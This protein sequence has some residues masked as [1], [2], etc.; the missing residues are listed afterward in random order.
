MMRACIVSDHE[1]TSTRVRQLLLQKGLDR[2]APQVLSL[3]Q[4]AQQLGGAQPDLLVVTLAPDADNALAVLGNLRLLT[5]ARILAVG[6]AADSRLILRAL[7]AGAADYV[8]QA[9]LEA[10]LVDALARVRAEMPAQAEPGRLLA[11]LAPSG[12]SGSSTLAV[13]VATVLAG[14]H[15]SSALFDLK[16]EAG[17]LAA[18]LDLRPTHTIAELCL[19]AASMDRVMFERSLSRHASGVHLL[20]A[21]R[22]RADVAQVTPDAVRQAL[23][24]ARNLFPY[25]VADLDHSFREEQLEVLSQADVV[26]VVL[27]LDFTALRNTQRT[28]EYLEQGGIPQDRVR[29]VVNRYGQP[30]EVPAAKAEEALGVKIAHYVPDEPKTVNRANNSGVP[31][32]LESPRASVSRSLTK[33]AASVNGRHTKH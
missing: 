13:N 32:V 8:D 7:R 5:A 25:V 1:P 24:V 4:A 11:L 33:L 15:K 3:V 2:P 28:L 21:P 18:L 26:L 16:L 6:P 31:V 19:N 9:D 29:L 20:A 17:D 27:R 22:T 23:A 14:E 30:K 10:G 12:G